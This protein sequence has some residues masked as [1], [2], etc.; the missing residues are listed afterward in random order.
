MKVT[1]LRPDRGGF[2][3]VLAL[4]IALV[5]GVL[6]LVFQET[7]RRESRG[8]HRL[9]RAIRAEVI[10][11]SV[12]TRIAGIIHHDPW[13]ERFYLRR[14]LASVAAGGDAPPIEYAFN[15]TS[16]P[17]EET[18]PEFASGATSFVGSVKDIS[19]M[20]RKYRVRVQ[21]HN[22]GADF[23]FVYDMRYVQGLLGPLNRDPVVQRSSLFEETPL[24]QLDA[25]VDAIWKEA[26]ESVT[27]TVDPSERDLA[28]DPPSL[29]PFEAVAVS[30]QEPPP[31]P[32]EVLTPEEGRDEA[33]PVAD[34]AVEDLEEGITNPDALPDPADWT[35]TTEGDAP[36]LE[37]LE[38]AI[39]KGKDDQDGGT[40]GRSGTTGIPGTTGPGATGGP[41]TGGSSGAA[42]GPGDTGSDEVPP[43]D[44]IDGAT[45]EDGVSG[46]T[47]D[48]GTSGGTGDT[49]VTGSPDEPPDATPEPSPEPSPEP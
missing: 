16:F 27:L 22:H 8:T 48:D 30:L 19:A 11:D 41:G 29:L 14:A 5:V 23:L 9:I 34:Q 4:V 37:E 25:R 45:G 36:L 26:R 46:S 6:V 3:L 33:A 13:E 18:G 42:G 43:D 10:A 47:G 20:D 44:G 2:V 1:P 38:K 32:T 15:H 40:T 28:A 49:G 24:D 35:P 39:D 31:P 17:F 7:V 21:V 12:I